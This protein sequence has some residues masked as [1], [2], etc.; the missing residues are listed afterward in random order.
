MD[1]IDGANINT[2]GVLGIDA[3]FG[4]YVSH[5]KSPYSQRTGSEKP[6]PNGSVKDSTALPDR[7][8]LQLFYVGGG[9]FSTGGR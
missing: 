6:H 9:R 7:K 8:Y 3:R 4:N 2:S 1:A 5:S